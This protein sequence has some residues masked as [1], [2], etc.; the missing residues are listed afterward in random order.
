LRCADELFGKSLFSHRIDDQMIGW[1]EKLSL[2]SIVFNDLFV[3]HD[4]LL[5]PRCDRS[6][7]I[8]LGESFRH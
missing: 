3:R 7:Q 4:R 5:S 1:A 6:I 8:H 2:W